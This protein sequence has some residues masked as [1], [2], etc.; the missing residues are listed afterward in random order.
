[1]TAPVLELTGISKSYGGLRPL[2]IQQ[3]TLSAG[4][5]VAILGFDQPM[6]EVFVNLVT[7]AALPDRGTVTVLGRPTSAIV[8]SAEWLA[9]VDQFGI[10]SDRAVM[11]EAMTVLQNLAMPF[12]LDI[13][14]PSDQTRTQAESLAQ[15]VGLSSAEWNTPIA[16]LDGAAR[17]CVSLGRAL[18]LDP[19]VLLLEHPTAAVDRGL[20]ASLGSRIRAVADR[21]GVTVVA[22]T[23]DQAFADSLSGRMLDL[24][25]ATGRLSERGA[26]RWLRRMLG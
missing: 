21:R 7:G 4:Q 12:T 20:V 14:P 23:A 8:D 3:L 11:L 22:V 10:V 6:A 24:D 17:A 18:A 1:M 15:E 9:F 25:P 26:N 5:R 16:K 2:R 19:A 13:E